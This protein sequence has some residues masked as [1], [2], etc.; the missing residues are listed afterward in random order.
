METDLLNSSANRS[1]Q[2]VGLQFMKR[3]GAAYRAVL[4]ISNAGYKFNQKQQAGKLV[5][6]LINTLRVSYCIVAKKQSAARQ[7]FY[8]FYVLL[9]ST[10]YCNPKYLKRAQ[11]FAQVCKNDQKHTKTR[12]KM[13]AK[14][15]VRQYPIRPGTVNA[16]QTLCFAG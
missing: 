12:A 9:T 14:L 1:V 8:G 3:R 4:I 10:P 15:S 13:I 6:V 7:Y 11:W 16:A 2:R 5:L